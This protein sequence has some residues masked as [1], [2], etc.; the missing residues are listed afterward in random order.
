MPIYTNLYT[1]FS[2]SYPGLDPTISG[3]NEDK[4]EDR[5]N[6]L[7]KDCAK[8][9]RIIHTDGERYG[10]RYPM[11]HAD[12]YMNGGFY[13]PGCKEDDECK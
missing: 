13:Q 1:N 12:F 6:M 7:N 5:E 8:F 10:V 11:G 4:K 9:V 2:I 3:W